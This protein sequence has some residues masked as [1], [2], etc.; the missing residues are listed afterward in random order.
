MKPPN[1]YKLTIIV[2]PDGPDAAVMGGIEFKVTFENIPRAE[3]LKPTYAAGGIASLVK[4]F[5]RDYLPLA[6][7][8]GE[9]ER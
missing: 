8:V 4:V 1:Q 7:L 3:I 9:E 5:E 6:R 2:A